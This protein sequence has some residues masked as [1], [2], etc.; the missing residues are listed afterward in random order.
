M[1]K[2]I[3]P[4]FIGIGVLLLLI[5]SIPR[6]SSVETTPYRSDDELPTE[7][8]NGQVAALQN[9]STDNTSVCF[10]QFTKIVVTSPLLGETTLYVLPYATFTTYDVPSGG[11]TPWSCSLH[12]LVDQTG[13]SLLSQIYMLQLA[14]ASVQLELGENTSDR[15]AYQCND[16]KFSQD[17]AHST[18]IFDSPSIGTGLQAV[19]TLGTTRSGTTPN[20]ECTAVCTWSYTIKLTGSALQL[21]QTISLD[22]SYRTD[23]TE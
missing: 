17:E 7:E 8:L 15:G 14:S 23:C 18:L 20:Q 2:K 6:V 3:W 13:S 19:Y 16:S 22:R 5:F 1:R 4:F 21:P 12:F 11:S 10:G 9:E